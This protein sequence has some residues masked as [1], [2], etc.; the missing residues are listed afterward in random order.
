MLGLAASLAVAAIYSLKALAPGMSGAGSS[1]S[2]A[3]DPDHP[4]VAYQ[5]VPWKH[6]QSVPRFSLTG[7]TGETF[8][9]KKLAGQP[10]A[11][12]FFFAECSTICRD[13]NKRIASVNEQLENTDMTFLSIS[14]DPETDTPEVLARY[15]R[16]FEA[17]PD[18]WAMLTGPKHEIEELGD[19]VFRV[20]LT[21]EFHTDNIL[22]VDKWGR[23]RDRFKWNDPYDMAR[24]VKVAKQ[25]AEE[26][27][28]PLD[29]TFRTRNVMAGH[30]PSN[31]TDVPWIREFHLT[32]SEDNPF[33]SRDLTGEVWIANFFF[34]TCP[35]IC[36]Q[37]N[38][39]LSALTSRLTDHPAKI[40]SITTDPSTD[41]PDVLAAYARRFDADARDWTFLT[42]DDLTIR[43]TSGEYFG[44]HASDG[45]HS[46]LL[47][48]VDKW[49]NVRGSFDWQKPEREV[50]MMELIDVL[51]PETVPPAEF[52]RDDM[53]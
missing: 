42:G 44:A 28:P 32:D 6:L 21:K 37:Q 45:H 24:F 19:H 18:R 1:G 30:E 29:Q 14:V 36:Q 9:T 27:E 53:K 48:V 4:G 40:V 13:L 3:D 2:P 50:A 16:D 25:L 26:T 20:N 31:I 11:V 46:S 23:W 15:A 12:S 39:Y 47:F 17:T 5:I 51:N 38:E 8:D 41:T 7:Q 22:L 43:R 33:Y 10:Y 34:S 49:G 35:G 52:E